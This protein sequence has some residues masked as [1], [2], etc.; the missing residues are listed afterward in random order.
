VHVVGA[1]G[2]V[3]VSVR[4]C[5]MDWRE[6][7]RVSVGVVRCEHSRTSAALTSSR[8]AARVRAADQQVRVAVAIGIAGAQYRAEVRQRLHATNPAKRHQLDNNIRRHT[9]ADSV[10]SA[11]PRS[12]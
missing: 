2:C 11:P 9:T 12:R 5:L 3:T 4:G 7:T 1:R 6:Y 10:H 8:I